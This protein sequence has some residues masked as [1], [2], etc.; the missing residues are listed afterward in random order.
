MTPQDFRRLLVQVVG[1]RLPGTPSATLQRCRAVA[2]AGLIEFNTGRFDTE[3][4]PLWS[5]TT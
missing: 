5:V 2:V 1:A 4:S 3:V